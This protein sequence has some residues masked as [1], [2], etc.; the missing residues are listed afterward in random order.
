MKIKNPVASFIILFFV[1]AAAIVG[2]IFMYKYLPFDY[3]ISLLLTDLAATVFVFIFSVIFENASVYDP[4][5]SVQPIVILPAFAI[6]YGVNLFGILLLVAV[7]YWGLRLTINWAINF[8]N[9]TH[10][11]WRYTMLSEKTGRF[12]PVV[13]LLGIHVFPTLVVYLCTLPAA[14]AIHDKVAFNPISCILLVL[15]II[16]PTIQ[17]IA[18]IQMKKFRKSGVKG[19]CRIGLWKHGRHPNYFGE[20]LMW[21]GIGLAC[22]VAM[23]SNWYLLCGA[24]VNT[25]MFLAASIPMAD[26]RQSRKE[27]FA[28][29][30][31]ETRVL[32]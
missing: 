6:A 23:K 20:I 27:G 15:S 1:Y 5:W 9:L 14:V 21:W 13:N 2:S 18:D 24:L 3:R 31:K 19:F 30:K 16:A 10:Q 28:E 22:V 11:D 29:Y 8:G 4:Y 25:I 7:G 12:Y 26:K 32:I 17:M